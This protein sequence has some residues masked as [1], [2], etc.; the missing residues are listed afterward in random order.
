MS[1]L[2]ITFSKAARESQEITE[3]GR[4]MAQVAIL[5]WEANRE[6]NRPANYDTYINAYKSWVYVCASKNSNAV[7]QS[8]LKLYA[9]K[10]TK[11]TRLIV[12]S[13]P[14]SRK[15]DRE[16]A[17]RPNL[18]P[19]FRKSE[20]REEILEHPVLE[21]L[22]QPNP[23]LNMFDLWDAT[24]LWLELT[25]NAYWYVWKELGLPKEIWLL[26]PQYMTI[27]PSREKMVAGYVF[28]KSI[29]KIPFDAEEVIHFRFYSPTGSLY[30]MG[31]MQAAMP[32][33]ANDQVIRVFESTLMQNMGR[34]EAVLQTKEGIS[35]K[36]FERFKQRW[37]QQYGG[38]KKVGQTLILEW[39]LEYKPITF[40]PKDMQYQV[41]RKS[42][43]EEIAAIFGV[44]M[45]KLTTEDV[46]RAN[47]NSGNWQYQNDTV[48][49][50]LRR[51]EQTL[52]S[53]LCPMYDENI[54]LAY[55]STLPEDKGFELQER[56]AHLSSCVTVVN[57]E[58][59]KLGMDPV[60][61][62]DKPLVGQG[63]HKLGEEPPAAPGGGFPG[64]VG[65]ETSPIKPPGQ[66]PAAKP[67][68]GEKPSG[69]KPSEVAPP[70]KPVGEAAPEVTPGKNKYAED[71]ISR[72][73][74]RVKEK[75][76]LEG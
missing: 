32:A 1:L 28:Q 21:L 38:A 45:S 75:L 18:A 42:N 53:F 66:K 26:P 34:P 30:G 58:R 5:P 65:P 27:V 35:D 14:I 62:G 73:Y 11:S 61:W 50:R 4:R 56:Q 17:K 63:I 48:E 55:D 72:V 9:G 12:K 16:L 70:V 25:G 54:F 29:D 6:L 64:E 67:K 44:P 8:S 13:A 22:K 36:E 15:W 52:N 37:K 60:E 33:Y 46:N 43:R 51:T 31:P 3:G 57:E 39:G 40:S 24:Q 49:P 47:A 76:A 23:F 20:E 7:A 68:P 2:D 71:L 59:E 74:T 41:G 19:W 69:T 10:K